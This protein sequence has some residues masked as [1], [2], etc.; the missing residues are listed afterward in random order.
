MSRQKDLMVVLSTAPPEKSDLL[1]RMLV[2]NHVVACVNVIPVRSYYRWKGE[3]C[4]EQEHLLVAKT[5]KE[6]AKEVIAAIKGYH[7]YEVPEIIAL[8]V[9]DGYLPYLEWVNQETR[10]EP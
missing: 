6:K 2:E 9:I 5:T 10:D 4:D 7:P 3:F 1:A 8:P